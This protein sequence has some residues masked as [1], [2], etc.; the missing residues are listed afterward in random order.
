MVKALRNPRYFNLIYQVLL[1]LV[2]IQ[3]IY[4]PQE[5]KYVHLALVF[6]RMIISEAYDQ[7]HRY[8]KFDEYFVSAILV[9]SFVSV[10]EVV[11]SIQLGLV[12]LLS[13]AVAV[14]IMSTFIKTMIDD[15]KNGLGAEKF[16][17]KHIEMLE[18]GRLFTNGLLMALI[19]ICVMILFYVLYEIIKL[20]S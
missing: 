16:H 7:K 10:I 14:V 20:L 4:Y 2:F 11:F 3:Q 12:Y 5:Y 1:V 18:K 6:I 19:G 15:S 13:L 9:T 8:L 17:P